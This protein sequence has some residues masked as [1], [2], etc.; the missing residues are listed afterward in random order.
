MA[1]QKVSNPNM[2][3]STRVA[4]GLQAKVVS[5]GPNFLRLIPEN[6]YKSFWLLPTFLNSC[7]L[8][9]LLHQIYTI[10][11]NSVGLCVCF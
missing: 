8:C 6:T 3:V 1:K 2:E 11:R 10:E 5:I 9:S 7:F 4:C